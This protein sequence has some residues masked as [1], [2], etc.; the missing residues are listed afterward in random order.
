MQP[1]YRTQ[2]K[3]CIFDVVLGL[4]RIFDDKALMRANVLLKHVR[5]VA[6]SVSLHGGHVG[7]K[8]GMRNLLLN[9]NNMAT[10]RQHSIEK[11]AIHIV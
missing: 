2:K 9:T 4:T 5:I 6:S 1:F 7:D 10:L 3:V 11:Q 8:G